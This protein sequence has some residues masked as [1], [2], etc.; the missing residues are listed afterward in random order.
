MA[1]RFVVL[2]GGNK[3]KNFRVLKKAEIFA[4]K[5][6]KTARKHIVT[7]DV[8][9]NKQSLEKTQKVYQNTKGQ[10]II[11]KGKRKYIKRFK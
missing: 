3:K 4:H 8:I 11:K 10:Y 1:E 7:I 6:F 9:K 5:K 2:F